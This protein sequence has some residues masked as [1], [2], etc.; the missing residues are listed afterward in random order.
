[1][2]IPT[3]R[4]VWFEYV[5]KDAPKAQAFF[6]ELF[7]WSTKKVPM[8]DGEYTMIAASDARTI[9]GY[10]ASPDPT[11]TKASWLPYLQV[12]SAAD[13]TAKVQ[14]LG[15][16]VMKPPFKVGDLATMSVVID[17]LGAAFAL[18][19]PVK[20]EDPG[21]PAAGHF[22]WNELASKDP[23]ASV[24][25]YAQIGGFTAS[26]M[27][28][29]GMGTYHVLESGG[30]G[31]AGIMAQQMPQQPHAWLPY[32]RVASADQT[33]DRASRLGA[34][35]VVPPSDIPGVG[36]IA[37]LVDAQGAGTGILQPAR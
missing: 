33:A 12:A 10:F 29:A 24:E 35:L 6:G 36:R 4:F 20:A 22:A 30:Q 31:R 26:K 37:I 27:E 9:G 3:G 7:G 14:A 32:V 11:A 23:A 16:S 2:T 21:T 18:W 15:G 5:S 8:P 19:Q 25:F 1:M 34:T 28:M 13:Q 17:P